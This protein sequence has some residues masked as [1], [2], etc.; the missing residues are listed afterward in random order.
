MDQKRILQLQNGIEAQMALSPKLQP[1]VDKLQTY[2]SITRY[3]Y[4]VMYETGEWFNV[5]NT[6]E[7]KEEMM[8]QPL[9]GEDFSAAVWLQHFQHEGYYL[10]DNIAPNE[11]KKNYVF[12]KRMEQHDFYHPFMMLKRINTA[13][14]KAITMY[15]FYSSESNKHANHIYLNNLSLLERFGEHVQ[16][17]L[18]KEIEKSPLMMPLSMARRKALAHFQQFSNPQQFQKAFVKAT[19]MHYPKYAELADVT[20]S[21]RQKEVVLWYLLGKSTQETAEIMG[22]NPGSVFTHFDRLKDKFKCYN[23]HQL[24]LKLIDGG[25]ISS[26]DWRQI[27]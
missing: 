25:F 11:G 4:T 1:L 7:L 27:Y 15:A 23:K 20:I 26:E 6:P 16:Q 3:T 2:F 5:D 21:K 18:A 19:G 22:L 12:R 13:R 14:G 17:S 9:E 8:S 24:L 10:L